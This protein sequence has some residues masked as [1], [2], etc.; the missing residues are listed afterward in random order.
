[1]GDDGNIWGGEFFKYEKGKMDRIFHLNEFD[2]ILGDKMAKEPKISA[3]A[4][5]HQIGGTEKYLKNKFTD[6]EWKIYNKLLQKNHLKS[7]SMGRL[8]DAVASLLFNFDVHSFEAEASMQ[9]EKEASKYYYSHKLSLDNSYID[10]SI[11]P[12][13][14]IKFLIENIISDL[15][16]DIDKLFIAVK[17]HI[18]LVDYII[19]IAQNFGFNK[20]AFSGG[21]FQ[22]ALLVDMVIEFMKD[23]FNLFFHDEFSPNDE[24]IPFGQL[25]YYTKRN[26]K[27]W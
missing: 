12:D 5:T 18:T 23:E 1:L 4:I 20:I 24:G 27:V 26:K 16:Q 25:M 8:F 17:F 19:R 13:N 15:D 6:T 7:T 21:V 11:L 22:N 9:F 2:F 3:L 10:N 14:F